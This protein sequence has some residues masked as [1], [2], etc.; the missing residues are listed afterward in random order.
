MQSLQIETAIQTDEF[1]MRQH[2]PNFP[3]HV[4]TP[5]VEI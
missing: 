1:V 4:S 2:A 5:V 3:V